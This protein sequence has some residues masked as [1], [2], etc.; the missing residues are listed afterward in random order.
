MDIMLLGK[1]SIRIKSKKSSL[2][3]DPASSLGKTEAESWVK[4]SNISDF[5]SSKIEGAR[6]GFTGPGEYEVG[7]IK[8]S[9]VKAGNESVGFFDVDGVSILAGTGAALEKVG[10][11]V[12]NAEIVIVN[13][14][15]EFNYSNITSFEPKVLVV[16][17][18][19]Q[20]EV[21]KA[22]GK[23]GQVMNKFSVTKDKLA[24]EMQFILLG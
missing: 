21:K 15:A 9:L 4:L 14:D 22:L 7:G 18:E 5:S 13:A 23:D 12:E 10:E 24:D 1:N 16:Y 3:I 17:G 6:V 11:K 2:I 8:I 20:D 19:K